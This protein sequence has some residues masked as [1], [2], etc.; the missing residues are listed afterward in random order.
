MCAHGVQTVV[1]DGIVAVHDQVCGVSLRDPTAA[2]I[3][4]ASADPPRLQRRV[5]QLHMLNISNK[6]A[7]CASGSPSGPVSGTCRPSGGLPAKK[8]S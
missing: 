1:L 6:A 7:V 4:K 2:I 8:R 3:R 5:K